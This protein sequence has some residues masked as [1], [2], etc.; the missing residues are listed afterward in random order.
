M[1]KE[2]DVAY[3]NW[4]FENLSE[5]TEKYCVKQSKMVG[6]PAEIR[7]GHFPNASQK[8]YRENHLAQ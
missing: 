8:R 1:L 2:V 5:G 7:T 6:V 3:F 4:L